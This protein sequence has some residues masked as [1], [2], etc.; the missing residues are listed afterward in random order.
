MNF[1]WISWAPQTLPWWFHSDSPWCLLVS[2]KDLRFPCWLF[3]CVKSV[4]I[5]SYS[6][7]HFPAWGLNMDR[8]GVRIRE[9]ADQDNSE[10]GHFLRSFLPQNI[11]L[12]FLVMINSFPFVLLIFNG[13]L[14]ARCYLIENYVIEITWMKIF[15]CDNP[16]SVELSY[17]NFIRDCQTRQSTLRH[18][19]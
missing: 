16:G 7:P 15:P 19:D 2:R 6:G 11:G 17:V 10:L 9:N 12:S 3:Y 5:W 8:Y 13:D 1:S 4:H 18:A 14:G